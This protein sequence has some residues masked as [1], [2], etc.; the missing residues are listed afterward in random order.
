M[1]EI[2]AR[3]GLQTPAER[4]QARNADVR[5]EI[6]RVLRKELRNQNPEVVSRVCTR[7]F[8]DCSWLDNWYDNSCK[9]RPPC[10]PGLHDREVADLIA[11]AGRKVRPGDVLAARVDP[12]VQIAARQR[13]VRTDVVVRSHELLAGVELVRDRGPITIGPGNVRRRPESQQLDRIRVAR[14]GRD[15]VWTGGIRQPRRIGNR[16]L[17]TVLL[18]RVLRRHSCEKKKN[19]F[20]RLGSAGPPSVYPKLLYRSRGGVLLISGLGSMLRKN[21]LAFSASLRRKS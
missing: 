2:L 19:S 11:M 1:I 14:L 20:L 12:I 5:D 13:P 9:S 3:T 15:I 4:A 6:R 8:R 21:E 18:S 10:V 16:Q 7:S 17:R